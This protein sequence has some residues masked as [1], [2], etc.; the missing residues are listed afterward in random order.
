VVHFISQF[1]PSELLNQYH[2]SL[3]FRQLIYNL[4]TRAREYLS[5]FLHLNY[6]DQDLRIP[7][8]PCL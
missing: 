6:C 4:S 2:F 7:L 3:Y 5:L 1:D 8:F